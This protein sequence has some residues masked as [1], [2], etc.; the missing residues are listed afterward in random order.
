MAN[1]FHQ[2]LD[3]LN[4]LLVEMARRTGT[5]MERAGHALLT[6]DAD[7]A[8]RVVRG[9]QKINEIQFKVD[10]WVVELMTQYQ[11]VATDLRFVLGAARI[12]TDLERAGDYA[13]HIAKSVL[14]RAPVSPIPEQLHSE[15]EAIHQAAVRLSEKT[16]HILENHDQ[17][18]AAQ[19][20]LDDDE[21]DEIQ[22]RI[23]ATFAEWEY[24]AQA[25]V[26][27]ALLARFFERF[28]DH[29]VRVA[30]QLVY[31]ITGDVRLDR[32]SW[33]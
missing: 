29:S 14:L 11:P 19:L 18:T 2:H 17:L 1:V 10:D 12:T 21:I 3:D 9:D 7:V 4:D 27:A 5:A 22:A 8:Q 15:F 20:S 23:H 32:R 24:G 30:H 6:V 16:V 13:K 31:L 28:G 33:Q 26:D 25:A